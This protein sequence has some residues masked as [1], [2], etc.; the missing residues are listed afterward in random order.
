MR[1]LAF[2]LGTICFAFIFTP[3]KIVL[4]ESH[5]GGYLYAIILLLLIYAWIW[6]VKGIYRFFC[7][8]IGYEETKSEE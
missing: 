5:A 2:L 8:K 6:I 1:F 3:V 4:M 7:K